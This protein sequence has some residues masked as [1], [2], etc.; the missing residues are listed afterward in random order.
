M[1]L[2]ACPFWR[3]IL[4]EEVAGEDTGHGEVPTKIISLPE[5]GVLTD[6]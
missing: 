3:S 1:S 5:V 6:L 4:K 2:A